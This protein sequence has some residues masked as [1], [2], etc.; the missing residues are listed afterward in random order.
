MKKLILIVFLLSSV[1]LYSQV[2]PLDTDGD[3]RRNVTTLDNLRW[4]SESMKYMS[5]K[6]ELDN[7]IDASDTKNWNDGKGFMPIGT[8]G[9]IFNGL[10]DGQGHKIE[11]LYI[12]RPQENYIGLFGY[13][14]GTK[15]YNLHLQNFD[16]VGGNYTGSIVGL[17]NGAKLDSCYSINGKVTG[18]N[19]VGGLIGCCENSY[20]YNSR[21]NCNV[22]GNYIAGGFAGW[23]YNTYIVYSESKGKVSALENVGGFAGLATKGV[24]QYCSAEADVDGN[25]SIGGFAGGCAGEINFCFS[26]GK[27]IGNNSA[28]GFLGIFDSGSVNACLWDSEASG[29]THSASGISLST[30]EL[31]SKSKFIEMGWNFDDIWDITD[32]YPFVN[33]RNNNKPVDTDG[34]GILNIENLSQLRWLSEVPIA[35]IDNY[36][37]SH[38]LDAADTKNWNSGLGFT[39]IG[40]KYIIFQGY[41][42][43]NYFLIRNLYIKRL[44]Q[45]NSGLFG[46]TSKSNLSTLKIIENIGLENCDISGNDYVGCLVAENVIYKIR[47]CFAKGKVNGVNYVGGLIGSNSGYRAANE[48]DRCFADVDVYGSGKNIGGLVGSTKFALV[49]CYSLGDVSGDENVGGIVGYDSTVYIV[50]SYSKGRVQG[51]IKIGGVVGKNTN[52]NAE[53]SFWDM[54]TSGVGKSDGGLGKSTAKMKIKS[55]FTDLGWDFDKIWDIDGVTNNGYPFLRIIASGV[56]SELSNNIPDVL[57]YPN[58]ISNMGHLKLELKTNDNIRIELCDLIGGRIKNIYS[59]YMSSGVYDFEIDTSNISSGIY[60][61]I[62]YMNNSVISRSVVVQ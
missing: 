48:V 4:M 26:T 27:V 34:N 28:G 43:G 38:D 60:R 50:N 35:Y 22:I 12:N 42:N 3:G 52:G 16:I 53:S 23:A 39:P 1:A 24:I 61:L 30:S 56:E 41:V 40:N 45:S 55:T 32:S 25:Y 14:G 21:T 19:Y 2:E 62:I 17:T 49:N 15:I 33:I 59:G 7:D 13:Y 31:K 9:H 47:N 54:E 46:F 51:N 11:N 37:L 29:I 8:E 20:I 36:E 57:V 6:Y 44:N 58:P 18:K 5:E 10:F